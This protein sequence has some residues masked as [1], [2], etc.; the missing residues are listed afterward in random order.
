[1]CHRILIEKLKRVGVP[2]ELICWIADYLSNRSLYVEIGHSASSCLRLTRGVPQGSPLGP[3]LFNL[4]FH[5][6]PSCVGQMAKMTCF[7]DDVL[8]AV[9][10]ESTNETLECL[11]SELDSFSRYSV[12]NRL[13]IN[14]AKTKWMI[15]YTDS[16]DRLP[17]MLLNGTIIERVDKFK[18][19]GVMLDVRLNW[20]AQIDTVISRVKRTM[21]II[22][23]SRFYSSQRC[24]RLLFQA[25][26]MPAF[27]YCIEIWYCAVSTLRRSL[28]VA[29]RQCARII[30]GDVGP[31]PI[32]PS[33]QLY[34]LVDIVPLQLLF[35]LRAGCLIFGILNS[36]STISIISAFK[37]NST[38]Y[39]GNLRARLTLAELAVRRERSRVALSFWGSK[40]W[41]TLDNTVRDSR[42]SVEFKKRYLSHI[43]ARMGSNDNVTTLP[44]HF[45]DF[46]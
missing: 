8:I 30:I 17:D 5:D 43:L 22:R 31:I 20:R 2:D 18:Y 38:S 9:S 33:R 28:E 3:L 13:C 19:L 26:V 36:N 11:K 12:E 34:Q 25:L 40:L 32:I 16:S 27:S 10:A 37:Y 24:S 39:H 45:Y 42:N 14:A 41:N 29:L 46:I 15:M 23:R 21:Y 44:H 7:A 6:A 4:F 1:V 35:Q